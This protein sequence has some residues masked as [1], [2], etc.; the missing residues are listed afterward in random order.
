MQNKRLYIS[1][2]KRLS[3]Q[4]HKK[5][6]EHWT[7]ISGIATVYLDGEVKDYYPGESI[8]IPVDLTTTCTI[9]ANLN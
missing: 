9:K 1:S 4:Y 7:V 8:D 5:R 2:E 6:S 3:L